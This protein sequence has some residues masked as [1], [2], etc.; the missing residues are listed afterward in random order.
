MINRKTYIAFNLVIWCCIAAMGAPS[1]K[2]STSTKPSADEVKAIKSVLR[3]FA[4][5]LDQGEAE[6]LAKTQYASNPEEQKVLDSLVDQA[7]AMRELRKS[8]LDHFGG[9]ATSH[10]VAFIPDVQLIDDELA[11][12]PVTV[13]GNT[14]VVDDGNELVRLVRVDGIWRMPIAGMLKGPHKK[15]PAQIIKGADENKAF[16]DETISNVKAGEFK[17]VEEVSEHMKNIIYA[18]R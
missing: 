4:V 13:T 11:K 8:V 5:A 2:P 6:E 14:A 17:T 15:S 9:A 10:F 3:T 16:I 7:R 1:T 12:M 18:H